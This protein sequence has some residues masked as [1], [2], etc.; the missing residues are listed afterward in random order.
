MFQG[1]LAYTKWHSL[2]IFSSA[3]LAIT[4]WSAHLAPKFRG[5]FP[6]KL[7]LLLRVPQ[8][9]LIQLSCVDWPPLEDLN[10]RGQ[11]TRSKSEGGFVVSIQYARATRVNRQVEIFYLLTANTLEP[12]VHKVQGLHPT[13]MRTH[14][15]VKCSS[16]YILRE[17]INM[18]NLLAKISSD[19]FQQDKQLH[20]KQ[21]FQVF[22]NH[23]MID[24]TVI[25]HLERIEQPMFKEKL[26]ILIYTKYS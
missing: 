4:S 26:K 12:W 19:I 9:D 10:T 24:C 13:F 25:V 21:A 2:Q 15:S 20:Q 7:F 16:G 8:E 17:C 22:S 23:K 3:A 14:C 11:A 18:K 5:F 6:P 1:A